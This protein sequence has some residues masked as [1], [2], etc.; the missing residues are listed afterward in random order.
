MVELAP[1][2]ASI[3]KPLA[4]A[5]KEDNVAERKK[6]DENFTLPVRRCR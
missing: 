5:I 2:G 1:F 4:S 3:D 6:T